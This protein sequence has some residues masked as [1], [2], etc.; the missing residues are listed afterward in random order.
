MHKGVY[1]GTGKSPVGKGR[2]QDRDSGVD[3]V[4]ST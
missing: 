3:C 2:E 4:Q 1:L